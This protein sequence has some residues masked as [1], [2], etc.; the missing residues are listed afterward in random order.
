[1][2]F[3]VAQY[4]DCRENDRWV[5]T[6]SSGDVSKPS[7]RIQSSQC[8]AGRETRTIDGVPVTRDCWSM[9]DQYTC[10]DPE[11]MEEAS[12]RSLRSSGCEQMSSV[13][14]SQDTQGRCTRYRQDF[15]CPGTAPSQSSTTL[16]GTDLYCADGTCV[17]DVPVRRDASGDF[18]RSAS[19]L[20]AAQNA[21]HDLDVNNM[22]M[23]KG[24]ALRCAETSFGFSNCCND[25]GWGNDAGLASCDEE[26]KQLGIAREAG[27]T[28]YVG[29]H[30]SGS[31]VDERKY[32]TF[33]TFTSKLSR[34]V[35]EQ[36]REQLS[37]G[38][39]SSKHPDCRPLTTSEV[40]RLDWE[41]MDFHEFYADAE[42]AAQESMQNRES[43][44][45]I[46]RRLQEHAQRMNEP[47]E[48]GS[49]I[50]P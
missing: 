16:C 14:L 41:R 28:H 2:N 15:R 23:F 19:A 45:E 17:S 33:C 22:S 11:E 48:S 35:Q 5:V 37:I 18:A 40:E 8:V 31:F 3:H 46:R 44:E 32:Q 9:K 36:G 25:S 20:A 13:C 1:M 50:A 39:G 12:C 24:E 10:T 43:T 27:R 29:S 34:L 42:A 47:S 21:A 4:C 30:T 7:C 26:E 49:G 38:W 6:S